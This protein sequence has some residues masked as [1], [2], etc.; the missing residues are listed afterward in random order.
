MPTAPPLGAPVAVF[1]YVVAIAS[2]P[3][4]SFFASTRVSPLGSGRT[5]TIRDRLSL[6]NA[7]NVAGS[8]MSIGGGGSPC[9]V[10]RS[11]VRRP[12]Q[13]DGSGLTGMPWYR[14]RIISE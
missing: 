12:H 4:L 6:G 10:G 5:S 7:W 2:R 13:Y 3:A 8:T 14:S 1:E 11:S 9:A